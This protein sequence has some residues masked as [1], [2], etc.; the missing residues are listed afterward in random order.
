MSARERQL[1]SARVLV[2][3]LSEDLPDVSS[4]YFYAGK[5][6]NGQLDHNL[7]VEERWAVLHAWAAYLGS[8]I[9]TIRY[10][11]RTGGSAG[12]VAWIEGVRVYVWAAFPK[13]DLPKLGGES[14]G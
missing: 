8:E 14:D 3:L 5:E 7:S 6:V 13:K 11:K 10:E 4:W 1:A 2:T 12:V 9:T